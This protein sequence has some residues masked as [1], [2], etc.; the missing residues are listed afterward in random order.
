MPQVVIENPILNLPFEEPPS[1]FR[2]TDDS[3]TNEIV[4]SR[5]ISS[6]FVPI[7]R[8]KKKGKQL[9]FDTE[10]TLDRIEENKFI[11]RMHQRVAQWRQGRYQG[12]T[13]TTRRLLEYW[14]NPERESKLFFCQIEPLETVIFITEVARK[15]GDPYIENE[16]R[17]V[18]ADAT[19]SFTV[20]TFTRRQRP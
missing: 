15:Y 19:R 14:T 5:R 13:P 20:T 12:V 7:P 4:E 6:Y 9:V 2:F 1:H 16:L 3:I 10:W 18:N 17:R 8:A 11:N